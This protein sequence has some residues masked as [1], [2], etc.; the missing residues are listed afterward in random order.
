[1][2]FKKILLIT[3][4][5]LSFISFSCAEK[6]TEFT[7]FNTDGDTVKLS[8]YKGKVVFLDFWAS[9]CPPC[10]MSIPAIK[11]LH[12]KMQDKS[13]VVILGLNVGE[14]ADTVKS[15]LEKEGIEYTVLYADN[16]VSK[17]YKISGIPAFFIID[18]N[19][20]IAKKYSGYYPGMDIQWEKDINDLLK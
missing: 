4:V 6:A 3:A 20:N 10:R 5:F 15:F 8:D 13:D 11:S 17:K 9:W 18:K 19:G 7:L 12:E 2:Q 1:M 16:A 14:G